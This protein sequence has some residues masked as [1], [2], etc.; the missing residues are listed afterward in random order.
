[1]FERSR[2]LLKP[3]D[4]AQTDIPFLIKYFILEKPITTY[5]PTQ[6]HYRKWCAI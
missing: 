6:F 2:E 5:H 4:C 1:M 3:F